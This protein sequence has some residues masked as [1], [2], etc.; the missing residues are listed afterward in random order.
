MF[1]IVARGDGVFDGNRSN[2]EWHLDNP[3][4][5]D[6]VQVPAESY[7]IIRFRADNP[8][9]WVSQITHSGFLMKHSY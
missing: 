9:V 5:R 4:Q 8:G 7:T 1:Q 6:T 2:V 3:A